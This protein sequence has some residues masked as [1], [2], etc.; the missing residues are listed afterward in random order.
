MKNLS[1]NL[2]N[3]V[4]FVIDSSG[5]MYPFTDDV[6]MVFDGQINYLALRSKDVDQETRV[7]VYLFNT[8]IKC[9][10]YDRDVLRLPSLSKLYDAC[11]GTALID[12]TM[13]AIQDLKKT[14]EIHADHAFLIFVIT[15]GQEN[16]SRKWRAT[17]MKDTLNRLADNWTLACL[18]PDVTGVAEAKR[19]GFPAQNVQLWDVTR[20]GVLEV[21][22]VIKKATETFM[23]GRAKGVRGTKNLFS[24]DTTA[25]NKSVVKRALK[26]L[27]GSE[28]MLLPVRSDK[29][30]KE[31]VEIWTNEAYRPGSA[32]YLLMK[33]E[34]VQHYKQICV[35]DKITGKV[36]SGIEARGLLGLPDYEVKVSPE[37]HSG[38][39]IFVQSSSVN[40]KLLKGTELIVLK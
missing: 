2:I 18:V 28:Y 36:Y 23:T 22:E 17:D 12:G 26:E 10:V 20:D 16:S 40:R 38:F 30:I 24:I 9:L 3:H 11:G 6:I 13:T 35:R 31:F 4:V 34:T 7:S 29:P 21:G 14:P 37:N 33:P 25:L 19:F 5:S 39:Q 15:D 8:Q 1:K 27:R 32:Y